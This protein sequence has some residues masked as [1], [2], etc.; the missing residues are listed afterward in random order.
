MIHGLAGSGALM[1]LVLSTI[2]SPLMGMTY[3]LVFG[4]GSIGGMM[5][6]SLLLSVPFHLTAKRFARVD[7][8]MRCI[9]GLFSLGFGLFMI[10][11]IGFVQGLFGI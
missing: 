8:A 7:L 5:A 6:M 9:A 11:Q 4:I 3:I 1:L 2:T 10:Y